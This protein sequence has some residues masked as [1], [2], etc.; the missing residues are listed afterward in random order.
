MDNFCFSWNDNYIYFIEK[1]FAHIPNT[2]NYNSLILQKPIFIGHLI[3][4]CGYL[5]V[6]A[7]C[8]LNIKIKIYFCS[9]E[10]V[11]FIV[12]PGPEPEPVVE[13]EK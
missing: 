8:K 1:V 11:R 13:K 2:S 10:G 12:E 5:S 6:Y 7:K 4:I 9:R 3:V